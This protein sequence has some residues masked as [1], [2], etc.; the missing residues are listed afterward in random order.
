MS[1][2]GRSPV[3]WR[4]AGRSALAL[5][6]H[7]SLWPTAV[8]Q[9]LRVAPAGW[10]RRRPFLPVPDPGYLRFRLQTAY[11]TDREPTIDDLLTYLR[12]CR[13]WRW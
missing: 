2:A 11:G 7:P 1:G 9:A 5:A 6:L 10:W 3:S 4:W 12:W 8:G 13:D